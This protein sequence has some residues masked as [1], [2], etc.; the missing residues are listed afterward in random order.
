M[1]I[2]NASP[3]QPPDTNPSVSPSNTEPTALSPEDLQ[4]NLNQAIAK[5]MN[6]IDQI[7]AAVQNSQDQGELNSLQLQAAM[8]RQNKMQETL[9]NVLKKIKDSGDS[10]VTNLKG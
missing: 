4:A 10:L 3:S 7:V 2:T 8:D 6:N 5:T 1:K 9:S